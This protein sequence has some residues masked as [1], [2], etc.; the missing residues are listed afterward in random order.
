MKTLSYFFVFALLA[1]LSCSDDE[2]PVR[3]KLTIDGE[4]Y[5][6]HNLYG[7]ALVGS[8]FSNYFF[9][10]VNSN[11]KVKNGELTGKN[12][13]YISFEF[14]REEAT[15][16]PITGTFYNDDSE[17][18]YE[19]EYVDAVIGLNVSDETSDQEY[20]NYEYAEVVITKS[21]SKF[22]I[23]FEG[24]TEDGTEITMTFE[25]PLKKMPDIEIGPL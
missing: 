18:H 22:K 12:I 2:V 24:V 23:I 10:A 20:D 11:G 7:Q 1:C 16:E 5:N 6:L 19:I 21:G 9:A 4:T 25:G 15:N 3:G 13:N 17:E 8:D 14:Y